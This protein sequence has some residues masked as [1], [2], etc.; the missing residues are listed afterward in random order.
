[1]A[2]LGMAGEGSGPPGQRGS[3]GLAP[4]LLLLLDA[5]ALSAAATAADWREAEEEEGAEAPLGMAGEGS[6]PLGQ[7]GSLGLP[8]TP[9][10]PP[11]TSDGGATAGMGGGGVGGQ[12]VSAS[13]VAQ[14][15]SSVDP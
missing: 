6:G 11:R 14:A 15:L 10:S 12:V 5:V 9:A 13:G 4:L 8:L 3:F 1:M 2:L 7:R